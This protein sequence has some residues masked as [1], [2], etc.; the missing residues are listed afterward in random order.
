MSL[1]ISVLG[2]EKEFEVHLEIFVAECVHV[3]VDHRV[4]NNCCKKQTTYAIVQGS[5]NNSFCDTKDYLEIFISDFVF[6]NKT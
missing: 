4:E 5:V 6:S 3:R 1:S 2:A